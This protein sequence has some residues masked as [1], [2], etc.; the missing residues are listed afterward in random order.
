MR[1]TY[2]IKKISTLK[3]KKEKKEKKKISTS[4]LREIINILKDYQ[5]LVCF[6]SK[7]SQYLKVLLVSPGQCRPVVSVNPHTKGSRV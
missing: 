4:I 1:K 3:V 7:L 2:N 6:L 5:N